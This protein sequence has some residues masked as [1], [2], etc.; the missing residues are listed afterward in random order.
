MAC[1][2]LWDMRIWLITKLW[3]RTRGVY[4]NVGYAKLGDSRVSSA[5][6]HGTPRSQGHSIQAENQSRTLSGTDVSYRQAYNR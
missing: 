6:V 4:L 3:V 1:A 2:K 5:V